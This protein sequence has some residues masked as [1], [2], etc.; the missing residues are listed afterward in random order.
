YLVGNPVVWWGILAAGATILLAASRRPERFRAVREPLA[1]LAFAYV[2][3]F[4]PFAAIRRQ[5][6]LYHYFFALI[7]SLGFVVLGIGAIAG[8]GRRSSL[9]YAGL[10]ITAAIGF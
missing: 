1:L 5:M 10:L 3:N 8:D 6:F 4:L 2:L 9:L 7:F